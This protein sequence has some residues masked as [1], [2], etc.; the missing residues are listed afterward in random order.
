MITIRVMNAPTPR[1][2]FTRGLASAS[3]SQLGRAKL[4]ELPYWAC[5]LGVKLEDGKGEVVVT[6]L[7]EV[8]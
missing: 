3:V 8:R 1:P 2:I 5:W 4:E 6:G 7:E